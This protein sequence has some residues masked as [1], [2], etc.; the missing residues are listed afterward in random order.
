MFTVTLLCRDDLVA[1]MLAYPF[2]ICIDGS[3]DAGR[4]KM[5]PIMVRLYD[6]KRESVEDRFLDICAVGGSDNATAECMLLTVMNKYKT[7][8]MAGCRP[9]PNYVTPFC[10]I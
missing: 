10:S 1:M 8:Y 6:V 4:E 2:S 9:L 5:Y 3:N 7:Q